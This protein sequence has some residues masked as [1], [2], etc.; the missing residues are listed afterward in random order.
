MSQAK[1]IFSYKDINI[2]IRCQSNEKIKYVIERFITT[3]QVDIKKIIFL[4]NGYKVNEE[5]NFE[6]LAN[7][8]DK[9]K[10]EVNIIIFVINNI[11]KCP[12]CQDNIFIEIKDNKREDIK[13]HIYDSKNNHEIEENIGT[14]NLT[15]K[16]E[17]CNNFEYTNINDINKELKSKNEISEEKYTHKN[18]KNLW[19]KSINENQIN[20]LNQYIGKYIQNINDI[21]SLLK[22]SLNNIII[23]N[24]R[25]NSNNK[26]K[27]KEYETP[28]N[29]DELLTYKTEIIEIIKEIINENNIENKFKKIMNIYNIL[30][31]KETKNRINYNNYIIG[32]MNILEKDLNKYV[33]LIGSYEEYKRENR[34]EDN[35]KEYR[36]KNE[37]ELKANCIIEINN[38][39]IIPFTYFYKFSDTGKYIIKYTFVDELINTSYLFFNCSTLVNL[40]LSN[41][42]TQNLTYMNGMFYGCR[43]LENINLSNINTKNVVSLS[44]M[45]CECNNLLHINLSHFNTEN[46]ERMFH[47]FCNCKKIKDINLSNFNTKNVI[48]MDYLFYG[49]N[50]LL[51][52]NLSNF[53]TNNCKQL[54]HMFDFCN[55]L[56]KRSIIT[57]DKKI[58]SVYPGK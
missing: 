52:V 48:N 53:D 4:Y 44:S 33:R 55:N 13:I 49:C 15:I 38:K 30:N 34:I 50:S 35:E 14:N 57:N 18:K 1:V 39:E 3:V 40:N 28:Q 45:F 6:E 5:L 31:A 37:E 29:D 25:I 9:S 54:N 24:N 47:M 27:I 58:L 21:I 46:V 20:D 19:Y 51:S 56:K 43:N 17:S 16:N 11:I 7:E 36:F 12:N 10:K 41:F 8:E 22:D 23:F 26:K 2:M 42:K 32:E